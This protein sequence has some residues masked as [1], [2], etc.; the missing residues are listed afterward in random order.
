MVLKKTR[1]GGQARN[2]QATTKQRTNVKTKNIGDGR[3]A[4]E[5][6]IL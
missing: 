6:N 1:F 4:G 5:L 2:K 3:Y